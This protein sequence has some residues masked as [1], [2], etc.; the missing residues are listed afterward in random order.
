MATTAPDH[1]ENEETFLALTV[2]HQ[3]RSIP[4]PVTLEQL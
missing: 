1:A 3:K 2:P 4:R